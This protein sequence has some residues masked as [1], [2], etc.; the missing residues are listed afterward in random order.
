MGGQPQQ[1][2]QQPP[3]G[4]GAPPQQG[5][6][7][8]ARLPALRGTATG[9]SARSSGRGLPPELIQQ[10]LGM[11]PAQAIQQL[12]ELFTQSGAPPEIIQQMQQALQ[13]PEDEQRQFLEGLLQQIGGQ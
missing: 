9:P 10:L 3:P 4:P 8:R 13:L 2:P 6:P 5:P 11:P 12:L 1:P 7:Q